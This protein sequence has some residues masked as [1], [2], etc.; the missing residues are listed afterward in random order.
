[1]NVSMKQN[2]NMPIVITKSI[3]HMKNDTEKERGKVWKFT[4]Y[5]VL[6]IASISN[7]HSHNL[8][9]TSSGELLELVYCDLV[10]ILNQSATLW[11]LFRPLTH[12]QRMSYTCLTGD[13]SGYLVGHSNTSI[14]FAIKCLWSVFQCTV[15]CYL[16][17]IW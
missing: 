4:C 13:K 5:S 15:K 9:S 12:W 11:T 16:V 1:M 10:P 17:D 7:Y 3:F 6:C 2:E 8:T 14:L